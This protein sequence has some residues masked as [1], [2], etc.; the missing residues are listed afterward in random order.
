MPLYHICTY[1]PI[2]PIWGA[3]ENPFSHWKDYL[4]EVYQITR[5]K[6]LSFNYK[7]IPVW[8]GNF[9]MNSWHLWIKYSCLSHCRVNYI[10]INFCLLSRYI[11]NWCFIIL[12]IFIFYFLPRRIMK[13]YCSIIIIWVSLTS[14]RFEG[15]EMLRWKHSHLNW[16]KTLH[17]YLTHVMH[18]WLSQ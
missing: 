3:R 10:L 8:I 17:H 6:R 9:S 13:Y 5:Q 16:G 15:S 4:K 18:M 11:L 14:I 2:V 1:V 7:D 12:K